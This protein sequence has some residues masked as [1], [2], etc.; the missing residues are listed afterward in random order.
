MVCEPRYCRSNRSLSAEKGHLQVESQ[1]LHIFALK[2][3]V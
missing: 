3:L 2:D 1:S